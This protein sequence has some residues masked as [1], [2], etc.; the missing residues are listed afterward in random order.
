[1]ETQW[2]AE[3]PHAVMEKRPRKRPRLT[4]D[5]PPPIPPPKIPRQ[6]YC[7]L[8][9]VNGVD[10]SHIFSSYY[11]PGMPHHASPP[12]RE[13]DKDGHYVFAVGDNLTPR[14]N[15][16]ISLFFILLSV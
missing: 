3:Y 16:R 11:Y 4:W 6:M 5:M 14:C 2:V 8:E 12:W 1:M 9:A 7:G 10:S 13:D 15:F